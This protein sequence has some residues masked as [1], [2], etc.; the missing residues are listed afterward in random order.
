VIAGEIE[1]RPDLFQDFA[2]GTSIDLTRREFELIQLLAAAE[3]RVLE[4]EE[5]YRRVWG[6][7]MA[8]GERSIDVFVRKVRSKLQRASPHWSYIHTHFGVGYR[9][10]AEHNGDDT[11]DVAVA[12]G[13]APKAGGATAG[14]ASDRSAPASRPYVRPSGGRL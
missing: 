8:H 2:R 12:A 14:R 5:I 9:F 7:T 3:G 1:V 13:A 10:S 4:R 11:V 6:Y